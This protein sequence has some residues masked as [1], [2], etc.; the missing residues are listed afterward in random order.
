MSKTIPS[1]PSRLALAV[2][3]AL[4]LTGAPV[5]AAPEE[6]G[7]VLS[8]RGVVTAS[9]GEDSTRAL[10]RGSRVYEGETIKTPRGRVQI[11][12]ADGGLVSLRQGARFKVEEY[13]TGDTAD[14][15]DDEDDGG[16]IVMRLFQG[17]MR[18]ITGAVG[19]DDDEQ[20]RM[21]TPVATVGIRGTQYELQ[22][23]GSGA[24]G[25]DAEGLYGQ[26]VDSRVTV[27]NEA[28]RSE[29]G[30]GRYFQVE[31]SDTAPQS[32]LR[33]PGEVLSS[34][35]PGGVGGDAESDGQAQG[36]GGAGQDT[37]VARLSSPETTASTNPLDDGA[38]DDSDYS[39]TDETTSEPL[40]QTLEAARLAFGI[41][42]TDI[43]TGDQFVTRL[44][45][46]S[47]VECVGQVDS[48]GNLLLVGSPSGDSSF[49]PSS[50]A[51]LAESGTVDSL[52]AAWGR[53]VGTITFS[54]STDFDVD[55]GFTWGYTR[56][57][58]T[59]TE[60]EAV[61]SSGTTV[62]YSN[63][64]GPSPIGSVDG[65]DW[66]VSNLSIRM[67]FTTGNTDARIGFQDAKLTITD[68]TETI[69][70]LNSETDVTFSAAD[71]GFSV[72]V[73]DVS[74]SGT[75]DGSFAG[76]SA[77]GLLVDFLV[78]NQAGGNLDEI[79]QGVKILKQ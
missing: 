25:D 78:T 14:G 53:W 10:N 57:P 15:A 63:P 34:G 79:I 5:V 46:L 71:D 60:R 18:T 42:G 76:D 62:T 8:A 74:D 28:G 30:K 65:A 4:S 26:V 37:T 41:A 20:Y 2:G 32:I 58:T 27:E 47:D 31:S 54:G 48:E 50:N 17:A 9:G 29:F 19:D 51:S 59:Q 67:E 16:S 3:A 64:S 49:D 69:E 1:H 40:D 77:E 7:R 22:Y 44:Q 11:R 36:A 21:E 73:S 72:P 12:F 61:F 23:C 70:L 75:I 13:D 24:C 38:S 66:A 35:E 68:G 33:P 55:G 6:V 45:C 39:E 52:D 43:S 56:N